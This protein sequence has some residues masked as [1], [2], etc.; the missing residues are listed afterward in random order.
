MHSNWRELV[1][2][3][4]LDETTYMQI[5][6]LARDSQTNF[7]SQSNVLMAMSILSIVDLVPLSVLRLVDYSD[8]V[9]G[10]RGIVQKKH[11]PKMDGC[12]HLVAGQIEYF[13]V[14]WLNV[15]IAL[16]FLYSISDCFQSLR[17][18]WHFP[19]KLSFHISHSWFDTLRS[20]A[21]IVSTFILLMGSPPEDNST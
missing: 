2:I 9:N 16:L 6:M 18:W 4:H 20:L 5:S 21:C 3:W 10:H 11:P 12:L 13:I 17:V 19:G 7:A 14:W 15:V 8:M 1:E